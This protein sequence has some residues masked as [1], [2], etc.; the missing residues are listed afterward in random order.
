M[1]GVNPHPFCDFESGKKMHWRDG[2][3]VINA[4]E[5][6][7]T[8]W[9]MNI[10]YQLLSGGDDTF[11]SL[12]DKVPWIEHREYLNQEAEERFQRWDKMQGRRAFKAHFPATL[13][14]LNPKVKYLIIV[15]DGKE[16]VNSLLPFYNSFTDEC[17]QYWNITDKL[18]NYDQVI[19]YMIKVNAHHTFCHSWWKHRYES[20]VLFVHYADL[21]K[22]LAG[23]I[24]IIAKFLEIPIDESKFPAILEYST[25]KWMAAH[26]SQI[27]YIRQAAVPFFRKGAGSLIRKGETKSYESNFTPESQARWDKFDEQQFPDPVERAWMRNGGPLPPCKGQ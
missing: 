5:K 17:R 26:E 24:R 23:S 16:V 22:D 1:Q 27:Q 10:V 25:F 19:D 6:C 2:D 3:I 14:E 7:G 9:T 4:G 21:K 15:R 11:E 18:E 8:H 13:I 20:N 12:Y